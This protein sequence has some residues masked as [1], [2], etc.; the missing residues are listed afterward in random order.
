MRRCADCNICYVLRQRYMKLEY[1]IF[2]V[3]YNNNIHTS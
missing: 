1:V 3:M 2:T